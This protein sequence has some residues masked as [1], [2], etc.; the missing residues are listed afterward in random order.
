MFFKIKSPT[1][2]TLKASSESGL[3]LIEILIVITL[4]GL[5]LGW[6]TGALFSNLGQ[7]KV[8]ITEGKMKQMMSSVALYQLKYNKMPPDLKSANIADDLDGWGFPVQYQ[9][10]DGGRSIEL[11]SLGADGKSGGTGADA[12]ILVKGP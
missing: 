8:G 12:D 4:I 11:R 3:T 9:V 1:Q 10:A 2:L 5:L 7:A 6:L